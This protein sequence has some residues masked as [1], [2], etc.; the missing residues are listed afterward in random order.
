M[1]AAQLTD[2]ELRALL[3]HSGH[4]VDGPVFNGTVAT[5]IS[6]GLLVSVGCDL[7]PTNAGL[8]ALKDAL[9]GTKR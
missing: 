4:R 9:N 3:R 1:N 7:Q 6:R 8:V 2:E 5:L